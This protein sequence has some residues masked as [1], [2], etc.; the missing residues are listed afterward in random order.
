MLD[1]F[2]S[3]FLPYFIKTGSVAEVGTQQFTQPANFRDLPAH[4]PLALRLQVCALCSTFLHGLGDMSSYHN[5]SSCAGK[6]IY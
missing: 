2:L 4:L 6:A 1:V 5:R 3:C